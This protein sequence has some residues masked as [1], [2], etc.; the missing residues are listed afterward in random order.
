MDPYGFD[1]AVKKIKD[2]IPTN[3]KLQGIDKGNYYK[4]WNHDTG[5]VLSKTEYLATDYNG[6][7]LWP[8]VGFETEFPYYNVKVKPE[9]GKVL[10]FPCSF[11]FP[12]LFS[13]VG[14]SACHCAQ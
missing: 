2:D 13:L 10:I 5:S 1:V 4:W 11:L 7:D 8:E 9:K 14:A 12:E 3:R 6:M